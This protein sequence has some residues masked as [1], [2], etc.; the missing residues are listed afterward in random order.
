[1]RTSPCKVPVI[2]VGFFKKNLKF[3]WHI[4]EKSSNIKFHQNPS[5]RSRDMTT[6]IV[7]SR[8]SANAPKNIPSSYDAW[9]PDTDCPENKQERK[10]VQIKLSS[11]FWSVA[12][13]WFLK[14]WRRFGIACLILSDYNEIWIFLTISRKSLKYQVSSKFVHWYRS[15]SIRTDGHDAPNKE[16]M[17]KNMM[18]NVW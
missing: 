2:L 12:Q 16:E 7:A 13:R 8:S 18:N 11:F 14:P 17:R 4:S 3:S 6:L 1:M 10:A 9:Q 15:C 5:N